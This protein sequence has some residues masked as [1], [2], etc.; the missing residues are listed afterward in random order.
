MATGVGRTKSSFGSAY[1]KAGWVAMPARNLELGAALSLARVEQRQGSYAE[2]V[3]SANPFDAVYTHGTDSMNIV[4]ASASGDAPDRP[5]LGGDRRCFGVT[6]LRRQKRHPRHDHRRRSARGCGAEL[7]LDPT[8]ARNF[9]WTQPGLRVGY[10]AGKNVTVD[11][12][13]NATV[14]PKAIGTGV[15]GGIGVSMRF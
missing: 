11:A 10:R 3:G 6:V 12:F 8:A 15:H 5:P 7:H 1:V 4:T 13:V 14:G 9:T 2:A